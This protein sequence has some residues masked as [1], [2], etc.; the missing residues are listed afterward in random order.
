M[1][2]I[3]LDANIVLRALLND[4]PRQSS[5]ARDLLATLNAERRGYLGV[6]AL[7]EI[8]WVLRSRYRIPREA[9]CETMR[10]LLMTEHLEI[11]TSDAVVRALAHYRKGRIDFQDALL[12]ERNA[13]SGCDYTLTLDR[14]AAKAI[15]TMELLKG[16]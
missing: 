15:P 3:G 14:D 9:L 10:E 6:S 1:T 7:L 8:F 5:A 16:A 4:H 2:R 13:E 12:A 11:E